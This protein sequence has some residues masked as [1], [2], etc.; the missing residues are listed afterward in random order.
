MKTEEEILSDFWTEKVNRLKN[1]LR[2][3]APAFDLDFLYD[4]LLQNGFTPERV[5][6]T[7][8]ISKSTT[9]RLRRQKGVGCVP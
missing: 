4:S 6:K 5:K 7:S 1:V 8:N 2:Y 3:G 9:Y